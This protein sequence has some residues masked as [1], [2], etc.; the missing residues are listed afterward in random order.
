MDRKAITKRNSYFSESIET[1]SREELQRLQLE[2]TRETLEW[3]YFKS[4]FYREH[5]D[6]VKVKPDDF[7][8]LDDIARFPFIDK[9][10]ILKDQQADPPFGKAICLPPADIRR[11]NLTSGTSGLGQEVHCHDEQ[12][13]EV[14]N[15]STACHFAAI[16]LTKG[17]LSALLYPLATMTGG[18]LAYEGLRVFGATPLPLAVFN[19]SQKIEVM[20]RFNPQHVLTTPAYLTRITALCLEK[21]LD[22]KVEFSHLK[23]IT[24]STEPFPAAWAVRMEEMWGTVIHDIYGSSQ[25]NLNYGITCKYGAVPD[26]KLGS[27]HLADHCA[28]VEVLDKDTDKPVDYGEWGEPVITTFSRKAMPLIRF[29]SNDRVKVLPPDFCDCGRH[30]SCAWEVGSVSRYDDMIKIKGA[31]VWPQTVDDI[32][33]SFDEI[34]EYSGRIYIQEDGRESA[35]IS[36]EFR[37]TTLAEQT[38]ES[39]LSKLKVRLKETTQVTMDIEEV[40]HGTVP[41]FQYKARR[42]TDERLEGLE[43]A[44]CDEKSPLSGKN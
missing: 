5:F 17:D 33:F 44:Q 15:A 37:Q 4:G 39:V 8:S 29:R 36:T 35:K 30:S 42:W 20:R 13:V 7:K 38:K 40:P 41:R 12:S 26:G 43:H 6:K 24:L 1:L 19:T 34:E 22:P 3:A 10:Q 27:Y 11:I 31:N 16:G 9:Q 23:G 14:A 21:G 2:K 28:L 18:M 25:L 32:V